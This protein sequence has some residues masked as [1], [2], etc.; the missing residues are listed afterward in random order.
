MKKVQIKG[1]K[2]NVFKE[3]ELKEKLLLSDDKVE[4]VLKY[5][6][7]FPEL[8]QDGIEGFVIDG[9]TLCNEL[10]V[11]DN[12]NTWLLG[13]TRLDSKGNI[14][15]Q[16]KLIKNRCIE[17]VDYEIQ[18]TCFGES[19][20]KKKYGGNNK[21]RILLTLNCAKKIAMRQNNDMGDLVCDYFII[22]E[23]TLRNYEKWANVRCVEKDGWNIMKEEIEQWCKRKGFDSSKRVFYTSE[24]NLIN[25]ALLGF[26]ATE[27]NFYLNNND[28]ITRDH[29]DSQINNAIEEIQS[30]NT[31][32]L[33]NDF[34]FSTR[35][36]MIKN[37]CYKKYG[38]IKIKFQERIK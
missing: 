29:L 12:F 24:A 35:E 28:K 23:E 17:S 15:S 38:D 2:V 3:K 9:E 26:D 4:L 36:E 37:I 25:R 18:K 7:T 5:Q 31:N 33:I 21:N 10:C 6:R 1:V 22:M 27:I 11:K 20:T 32:L 16:G 13:E 19:Q 34:D 30:F 8:L 14:K